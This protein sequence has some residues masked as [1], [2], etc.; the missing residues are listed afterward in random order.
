ML[1]IA[2]MTTRQK[3]TGEAR[4]RSSDPREDALSTD[5]EITSLARDLLAFAQQIDNLDEQSRL[6]RAAN[7]LLEAARG[8][9]VDVGDWRSVGSAAARVVARITPHHE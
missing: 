4:G 8:Q 9:V 6:I 3:E 2:G 1:Q 7:A 5:A